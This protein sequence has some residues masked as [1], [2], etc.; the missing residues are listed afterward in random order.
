MMDED[1]FFDNHWVNDLLDNPRVLITVVE[2]KR[3]RALLA[4]RKRIRIFLEE[5][6]AERCESRHGI[7]ECVV[8]SIFHELVENV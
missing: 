7:D 5:K 6:W 1:E 8:C 3:Q 4:Q 2:T